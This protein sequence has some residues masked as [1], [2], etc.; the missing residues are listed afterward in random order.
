MKKYLNNRLLANSIEAHKKIITEGE[1]VDLESI[2]YEKGTPFEQ[3]HRYNAYTILSI[4]QFPKDEILNY[5]SKSR[6]YLDDI[7]AKGLSVE[8]MLQLLIEYR[9]GIANS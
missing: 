5:S 9:D 3:V 7:A 2:V 8:E 6:Q 4:L 1:S